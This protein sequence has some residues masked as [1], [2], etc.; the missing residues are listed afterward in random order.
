MGN[1]PIEKLV[2]EEDKQMQKVSV[3][4]KNYELLIKLILIIKLIQFIIVAHKNISRRTNKSFC[5]IMNDL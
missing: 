1:S 4:L 2:V 5:I 3:P